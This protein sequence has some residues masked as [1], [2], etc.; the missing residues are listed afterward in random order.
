MQHGSSLSSDNRR[1]KIT[2]KLITD[3]SNKDEDANDTFV[4]RILKMMDKKRDDCV[5]NAE[6]PMDVA[7]SQRR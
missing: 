1:T 5:F 7:L 2:Q 4:E 3:H 6:L